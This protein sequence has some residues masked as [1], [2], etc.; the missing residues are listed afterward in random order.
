MSRW[1]T[2]AGIATAAAI[3]LSTLAA[4]DETAPYTPTPGSVAQEAPIKDCTR[5]NGHFGFY[6]NV[7]CTPEEQARWDKYE[8]DRR[9]AATGADSA[10]RL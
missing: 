8:A 3:A 6:G 2:G 4:A 5:Y 1:M 7:W 10:S 9:R